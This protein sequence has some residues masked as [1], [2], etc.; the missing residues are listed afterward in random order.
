[1]LQP[2]VVPASQ[3]D[4]LRSAMT[5]RSVSHGQTV[6]ADL[7]HVEV[8]YRGAPREAVY[9]CGLRNLT[10]NRTIQPGDGLPLP[11]EVAVEGLRVPAE[12]FYTIRNAR[13]S[14]NG[15]IEIA[16][17]QESDVVAE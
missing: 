2:Q 13:I 14:S 9:F 15:R 3:T 12:G 8:S 5:S 11:A 17:D 16:V 4:R 6:R 1:M 10:V 7:E